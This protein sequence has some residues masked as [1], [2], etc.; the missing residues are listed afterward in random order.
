MQEAENAAL[1]AAVASSVRRPIWRVLIDWNNDGVLGTA[2]LEII[3]DDYIEDIEVNRALSGGVEAG[4][5]LVSGAAGG[6]ATVTLSGVYQGRSLATAMSPLASDPIFGTDPVLGRWARVE[7]GMVTEDGPVYLPQITGTVRS[8]DLRGGKV[9][10]TIADPSDGLH[11]PITLPYWGRGNYDP[12][13]WTKLNYPYYCRTQWLIDYALRRNGYGSPLHPGAI[14]SATFH[15]AHIAEVGTTYA[16]NPENSYLIPPLTEF[17]D[18][19]VP[20]PHG[21]V[22][23]RGSWSTGDWWVP[24]TLGIADK[25]GLGSYPVGVGVS[26]WYYAGTN[27]VSS[28]NS[29]VRYLT[30]LKYGPGVDDEIEVTLAA[31]GA[32]NFGI[33]GDGYTFE[34]TQNTAGNEIGWHYAGVFVMIPASGQIT[35]AW[36]F[37][38]AARTATI[39]RPS[40]PSTQRE[41]SSVFVD[42]C[43]PVSDVQWWLS[44]TPPAWPGDWPGYSY[45]GSDIGHMDLGVNVISKLPERIGVDSWDFVQEVAAAEAG[46]VGFDEEGRPFFLDR[47]SLTADT[48]TVEKVV[49]STRD[50]AT[51]DVTLSTDTVRNVAEVETVSGRQYGDENATAIF[52]SV[53]VDQFDT[54][55]NT[56]R[57]FVVWQEPFT[58]PYRYE[59]SPPYY[60]TATWNTVD[61]ERGITWGFSCVRPDTNAEVSNVTVDASPA[62]PRRLR[63]RVRNPNNFAVRL[64]TTDGKPALRLY[65]Y[66]ILDDAPKV[67]RIE[68]PSSIEVYGERSLNLG[69]SDWDQ[70]YDSRVELADSLLDELRRPVPVLPAI[71]VVGDPRVQLGDTL[72]IRSPGGVAESIKA[73]VVE[74]TR[75]A[76]REGL[77]DTYGVRPILADDGVEDPDPPTEDPPEDGED[78]GSGPE[79]TA[80]PYFDEADWHWDPIPEDPVLDANSSNISDLL[81][82][83][84][85]GASRILNVVRFGNTLRGPDGIDGSTPRYTVAAEYAG[86]WGPAFPPGATIPIP[87]G[88]QNFIPPGDSEEWRDSHV[89]IADPVDNRVYSMWVATYSPSGGGTWSCGWGGTAKLLGDGSSPL[90]DGRE[91][92]GGSTGAGISRFACVVRIEE[93]EEGEIPHALFFSTDIV[94]SGSSNFVYPATK[95][96]GSNMA[97]AP[98]NST[99]MEGQ[100]V[101]LN[102][103]LD[104]DDYGLNKA[105][106]AIMVAL[107][108]YGAYCGDNGGTRMAFL[109]ELSPDWEGDPDDPGDRYAAVG[110]TSDYYNL[111]KI[112]WRIGGVPQLRVLKKWDG[113]A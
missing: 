14:F 103:S 30:A 49:T 47:R 71:D 3:G 69:G 107:Q 24:R 19:W 1:A 62:G 75:R 44:D 96:D 72:E 68:K 10:L 101:Q 46:A 21:F 29:D 84:S 32:L 112:P 94:R 79:P 65:G 16:I 95:T 45:D 4:A 31:N 34:S 61:N 57:D 33:G 39:P 56:T 13:R 78:P 8:I 102:P 82:S 22:A 40:F 58:H 18:W 28:S 108:R 23:P 38:T 76:S 109:C 88:T 106:K 93:L 26:L 91:Y 37:D 63:V 83:T 11:A 27:H 53:S 51:L 6:Q 41:Y 55:A 92:V 98:T 90:A 85:G 99:I 77:R 36:R 86:S 70:D 7:M 9:V 110:I 48:E 64:A 73:S 74:I 89:S 43:V 12:P 59:N 54:P 52:R 81:T 15:G 42:H 105:E 20:G 2:P 100:R 87:A 35:L 80:R 17:D 67:A 97:G 5:S 111:S 50:L 66:P 104:P 60:D 25:I 113:S